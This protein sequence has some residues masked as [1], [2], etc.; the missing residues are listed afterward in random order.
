M[1]SPVHIL[2]LEDDSSDA[3]L[4]QELLAEQIVCEVAHVQTRDEFVA[5]LNNTGIDLILADYK[6]PSFDGWLDR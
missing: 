5:A 6:L 3:E 1:T 2:L 4:I